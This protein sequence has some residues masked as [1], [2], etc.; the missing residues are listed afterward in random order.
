MIRATI[1]YECGGCDAEHTS[2]P[3][4]LSAER[5]P[6]HYASWADVRAAGRS[7]ALCVT[8]TPKLDPE[9]HAPEGWVVFDPYT[10]CTYCPDCWKSIEDGTCDD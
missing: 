5:N 2:N 1:K 6:L 8:E 10:L 4:R 9:D 7:G 3:V